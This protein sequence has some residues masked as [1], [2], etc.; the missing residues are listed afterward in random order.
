MKIELHML[1]NFA[2]SCL[3]RDDTNA[4]KDCQFGGF[5]R[6]RISSQCL[7]RATRTH[8]LFAETVGTETAIRSRRLIGEIAQQLV[9]AGR[10]QGE[11]NA[12]AGA[13]MAQL[14]G[15]VGD[16]GRTAVAIYIGRAEIT[17][18]VEAI[19][20]NWDGLMGDGEADSNTA[21]K[22]RKALTKEFKDIAGAADIALF[23]RMIAE[24]TDL[25]IDA[26]CQV[27]HAISTHKAAMEMDF[28]T[29]VD[30]LQPDEDPGAGMMGTVEFNSSCFY[31]YSL[32][33]LPQLL[34]N[35]DRD[36]DLAART[37]DGLLRASVAAIPTGKQ[38]SMAAQNPP[39]FVMAVVRTSG[40]PW[41]LVNAF[42]RPVQVTDYDEKGLVQQSIEALDAYWGQL[43]DAYGTDGIVA[44]PICYLGE[45]EVECLKKYKVDTL[46]Q[47]YEAVQ[48]AITNNGGG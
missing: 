27:A 5:R 16:D 43:A 42:E 14:A 24:R 8:P 33:D 3:N 35:L 32:I 13:I 34:E 25:N 9:D 38:H 28:Y 19:Q 30:D 2:P 7:K 23:G 1:Q 48:E 21:E 17:R 29:A 18:I 20:D 36:D 39:S 26:A 40:V 4:P 45:A 10:S 41:S 31:R 46:E 12:A 47:L 44:I 11:A 37:V 6:A 15:K 22:L